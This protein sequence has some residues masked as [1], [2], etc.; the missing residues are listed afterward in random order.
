MKI[1]FLNWLKKRRRLRT[2][3][4]KK[5]SNLF[6]LIDFRSSRFLLIRVSLPMCTC[7]TCMYLRIFKFNS[8]DLVKRQRTRKKLFKIDFKLFE[9]HSV[10]KD[11]GRHKRTKSL[12]VFVGIKER[13]SLN[14]SFYSTKITLTGNITF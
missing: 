10:W 1:E 11:A 9:S 14:L 8:E 3:L 6:D 13:T 4:T 7:H 12:F 5:Q 2:K